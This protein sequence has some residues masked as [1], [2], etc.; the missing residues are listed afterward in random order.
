[1]YVLLAAELTWESA[2]SSECRWF[3]LCGNGREPF[4]R[5]EATSFFTLAAG[6]QNQLGDYHPFETLKA[7]RDD[8]P[9]TSTLA[10]PLPSASRNF[11]PTLKYPCTC[12][13]FC[14]LWIWT[15][16]ANVA[17]LLGVKR[18]R[19]RLGPIAWW[20]CEGDGTVDDG[21]LPW[22]V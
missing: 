13:T 12:G 15:V 17:V 14:M 16:T 8:S 18:L 1:M 11:H 6:G 10:F 5:Q 2:V 20:G 7:E 19:R 9:L 3:D 21:R 4:G 22:A